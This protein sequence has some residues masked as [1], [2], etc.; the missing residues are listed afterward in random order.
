[1]TD[2]ADHRVKT[3]RRLL[4]GEQPLDATIGTIGTLPWDSEEEF[5][6]L[7]PEHVIGMLE[8]FLSGEVT[9]GDLERWANAIEGRDDIGLDTDA[10]DALKEV[11]FELANPS[12]Q[13]ATTAES[14]RAW[15]GRLR[16]FRSSAL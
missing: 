5:V 13:G 14:A 12:L 16:S 11:I 8:R 2:T 1:M 6:T 4:D 7:T 9:S 10:A 3:L 15:V